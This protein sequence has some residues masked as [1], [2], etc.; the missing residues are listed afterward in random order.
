MDDRDYDSM[1]KQAIDKKR[2]DWFAKELLLF[3]KWENEN[4]SLN[5]RISNKDKIKNYLENG[6][7]R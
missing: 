6:Y 1:N 3:K 7:N 5:S 2:Y 4:Y